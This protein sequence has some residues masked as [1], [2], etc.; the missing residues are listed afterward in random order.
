MDERTCKRCD[1]TRPASEF[2]VNRSAASGGNICRPCRRERDAERREAERERFR[3]EHAVW[4][5]ANPELVAAAR[6][7]SDGK[8]RDAI[9]DAYGRECA[10]CGEQHPDFLTLDHIEGGGNRHRKSI[11]GKVYS[12]LRRLGFPPGYRIL[13][14]NCNWAYRLTGD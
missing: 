3:T 11:H 8:L 13:C 9:L 1:T 4:R 5:L 10:C 12:Q 7:R 2:V 14:W 6:K